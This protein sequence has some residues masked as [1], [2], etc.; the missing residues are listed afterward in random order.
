M[1]VCRITSENVTPIIMA[2]TETMKTGVISL[3]S[4]QHDRLD[5]INKA[6][7]GFITVREAAQTLGVSERQI[8]RLKKEVRSNGP[9]ALVHKNTNRTPAHA[10]SENEKRRILKIRIKPGYKDSNF[11]H[12]QELLETEHG[13][14][15]SYS[16]L[17]CLLKAEGIPSPKK[18]RR[19]KPHRRRKRRPQAGSLVQTDASPY[20]WLGLETDL[21]LHG[22]IDDATSQILGL[23]LCKNECLLGYH[24]VTRRMIGT[25]GVP[26]S[27]YADRHTIFRSPNEDKA[28]AVD[29]PSGIKANQT[30]FGRA[31]S[32]L[33]IQIIAARSAQ[34]KG[35]IERLWGT[36][37]SRL[38]VEFMIHG[39]KD[40]DTANAFLSDYIYAYNSEFAVEPEDSEDAFLPLADGKNLDYILCVKED[41][42]LDSGQVFSY[43]GKRFQI[44]K[45]SYSNWI[46]PKAKIS[47]MTSPYIGIMAAYKN[48]VFE[49]EPA[50]D[51]K[52]S[53]KTKE[54]K[55]TVEDLKTNN[56]G[57]TWEAKDG[58]IW[59]PGL[60][61]Y[62]ESLEIIHEIFNRPFSNV[63]GKKLP[64]NTD[65]TASPVIHTYSTDNAL[66]GSQIGVP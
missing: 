58:L 44:V 8:Q 65:Y 55:T 16:A 60:P 30:Q 49:T 7:A 38:P 36:L 64:R 1:S 53:M 33:G 62:R 13:I 6:N 56:S 12:F 18:R 26:D 46:P 10:L 27:I 57:R 11:K 17:C 37:Q 61:S 4:E 14:R 24:E 32:E 41:R 63:K 43:K 25:F 21:S 54:V 31:M 28:K 9:A 50:L 35:R 48:Y 66:V 34:A 39:I 19:F 40:I 23:Y 5:T 52:P 59:S 45:N 42:V 29:A 15:I 20:D 22:I 2:Y 47:V 3:T 51:K